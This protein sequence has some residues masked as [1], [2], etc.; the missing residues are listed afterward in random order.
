M[1]RCYDAQF[2]PVNTGK[3]TSGAILRTPPILPINSV[4]GKLVD[5]GIFI[6]DSDVK[7]G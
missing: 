3:N 6:G 7:R 2:N 5:A 4:D 1:C